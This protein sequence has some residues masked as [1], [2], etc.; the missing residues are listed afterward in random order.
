MNTNGSLP[1]AVAELA[2]AGLESI[3]VSLNSCRP[4]YYNGYYHPRGYSLEDL[5]SSIRAIKGHGGFA[6]LNYFVLPGFTDEP[7][8]L[9]ALIAFVA[10]TGVDLIQLRNFNID[11]EW[12]LRHVGHRPRLPALGVRRVL[13]R[14]RER[15]PALRF[16]YYNPCLDAQA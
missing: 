13:E 6:S 12:Y 5:K 7:E 14:L 1:Q 16:G 15:F 9:E 3:R 4:H 11:P 2:R 8:E 10:N